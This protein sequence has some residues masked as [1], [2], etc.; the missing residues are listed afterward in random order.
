MNKKLNVNKNKMTEI[1]FHSRRFEMLA[2]IILGFEDYQKLIDLTYN[3]TPNFDI[4]YLDMILDIRNSLHVPISELKKLYDE[5]S[6]Y[7]NQNGIHHSFLVLTRD[8]WIEFEEM[9]LKRYHIIPVQIFKKI[10]NIFRGNKN[11]V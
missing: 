5:S 4:Q 10:K 7:L 3:S 1:E 6:I 9:T 11:F 2:N 8:Q